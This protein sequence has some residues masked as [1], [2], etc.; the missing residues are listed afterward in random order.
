MNQKISVYKE[1]VVQGDDK[2]PII[3]TKEITS[4]YL[5]P[6]YANYSNYIRFK[7]TI[8]EKDIEM[9]SGSDHHVLIQEGVS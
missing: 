6:T 4:N 9:P 5:S 2:A 8:N 1:S 3:S 7:F